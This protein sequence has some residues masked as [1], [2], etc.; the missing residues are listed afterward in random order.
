MTSTKD[1]D[2][3]EENQPD[4]APEFQQ[5][6]T[7]VLTP[8][9]GESWAELAATSIQVFGADLESGE[10]LVS[11][12]F[13]VVQIQFR[14]GDYASPADTPFVK[15]GVFGSYVSVSVIVADEE[16]I[17][18]RIS[19]GRIKVN[20]N[21]ITELDEMPVGPGEHL[22]FN[23]SGPGVYR[24]V[25]QTLM[26]VGIAELPAGPVEGAFGESVLDIPHTEWV[27][28]SELA[29]EGIPIRITCPRGLRNSKPYDNEHGKGL[30]TRYFG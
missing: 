15:K 4:R 10:R 28:G 17:L 23:E 6:E 29:A 9:A 13:N 16:Y 1:L 11:V 21:A 24:Q 2:V 26:Q 3:R 7:T 20:G 8:Y 12:P 18:P 5:S 22:L 27:K 30:V 19:R 25:V 14:Q